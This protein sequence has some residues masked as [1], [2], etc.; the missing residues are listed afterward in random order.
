MGKLQSFVVFFQLS[1]L[2]KSLGLFESGGT[3]KF[4]QQAMRKSGCLKEAI[5]V[6]ALYV[7][8]LRYLNF[9]CLTRL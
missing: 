7:W 4:G 5:T 3:V 1:W 8:D 9:D 6:S 2:L